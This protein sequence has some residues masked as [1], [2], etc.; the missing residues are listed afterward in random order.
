[1]GIAR[2]LAQQDYEKQLLKKA[3]GLLKKVKGHLAE[4]DDHALQALFTNMSNAR[5]QLVT[6]LVISDEEYV[7]QWLE[8]PYSQGI[9]ADNA[10]LIYSEGG[11]RIRSKSEKI[12]TDKYEKRGSYVTFSRAS[13]S[14]ATYT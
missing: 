3:K 12:I 8:V 10:P 14:K 7:K 13:F 6:P 5:R 9:F 2:Q 11:V 1:M 4:F